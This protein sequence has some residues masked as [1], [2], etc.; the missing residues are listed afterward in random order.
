MAP[1]RDT[2]IGILNLGL[3]SGLDHAHKQEILINK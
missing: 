2:A 3:K 1:T